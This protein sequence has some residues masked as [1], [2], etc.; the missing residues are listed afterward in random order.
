MTLLYSF[1]HELLSCVGLVS[2]LWNFQSAVS[3]CVGF[4][5]GPIHPYI[6]T[7]TV[8]YCI[9]SAIFVILNNYNQV[10]AIYLLK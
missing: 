7:I 5:L 9:L 6:C 8:K 4:A 3:G 10:A 1:S 2:G